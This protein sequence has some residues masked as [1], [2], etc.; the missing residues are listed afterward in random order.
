MTPE[1]IRKRLLHAGYTPVPCVG[2]AP[3][4]KAWQKQ[5]GPTAFD[6]ESWSRTAPAAGNTGLLTRLTPAFD[7]DILAPDAAAAVEELVRERF[8][9]RGYVLPRIGLA[10]K[11]CIPFRT[12]TPFPK[13]AVNFS[14]ADGAQKLE[15]LCDGQQFIAFGVHPDTGEPYFWPGGSPAEIRRE[16]LPT[17]HPEEA[18]ALIDD[19]ARILVERFGYRVG[20][21]SRP[22]SGNGA[23]AEP[24][25]QPAPSGKT[26]LYGRKALDNACAKIR[27]AGPGERDAAIGKVVLKIGSLI[28]GGEIDEAEA[29]NRLLAAAMLNGGDFA[30]QKTKIERAAE[31]GKQHPKSAPQK[32]TGALDTSEDE[33]AQRFAEAHAADMRYVALW[34]KWLIFDGKAWR[35]DD[36]LRAFTAARHICRDA[37]AQDL[38]RKKTLLSAATVAAVER[39]ARSDPRLAAPSDQWDRDIW[40]LNTPGG[41]VDLRTGAIRENRADNYMTQLAGVA[42]A[43]DAN[44]RLAD[45]CPT[46][47]DFLGE[48]FPG[49]D[50]LHR[51]LQRLT[52][53]ACTG[54]TREHALAFGHGVGRNGKSTWVAILAHIFGDYHK[55]AE[56][57]T[58]LATRNERHST[59]LARLAGARLVTASEPEDRQRWA[60]ARVKK[61]TG[62]DR[63]TARFMRQDNFQYDP[64]FL[65]FVI[66]NHKPAFGAVDPALRDRL[67]LLPFSVY[68]PPE[69][70]DR[71][72][73]DKLKAEAGGILSWAIKGAGL[74]LKQ[75][76][77]PPPSV[78][79]ATEAYLASEDLFA[80]WIDDCCATAN[81]V[82]GPAGA[83]FASWRFFAEAQGE[84]AGT[85]KWFRHTLEAHGYVWK[86]TNKVNVFMGLD[87]SPEEVE[88][89]TRRA[90][91]AKTRAEKAA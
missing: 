65:L 29:L 52:G 48:V 64:Q 9:E 87:L 81:N 41:V 51:F 26:T 80:Q 22:R 15:F 6:I 43:V 69:K 77:D 83:L 59:E 66:G 72:L 12:D 10:P 82:E 35:H 86:K 4:L 27:D 24:S 21:T 78:I 16:G 19:A 89:A 23:G 61:L 54:S 67:L 73:L 58:F 79:A 55:T 57:E 91:E 44:G 32:A 25:P 42:P 50:K 60:T 31:E 17:I 18:Q 30:E 20:A 38:T 56:I 71:E 88:R 39:L 62:G 7:I 53:Y 46:F 90:E 33:L 5:H 75:G 34:G 84:R 74:W 14:G 76:L 37:A 11:R 63:I 47:D 68:F 49:D 2:K 40:L 45:F 70:R 1:D 36:T 3:I 13:I 85:S 8:E 28:A